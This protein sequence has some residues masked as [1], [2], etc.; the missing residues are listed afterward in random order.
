MALPQTTTHLVCAPDDLVGEAVLFEW[1]LLPGAE[2]LADAPL[3]RLAVEGEMRLVLTPMAGILTERCVAIGE[4]LAANDLL[5][6]IEAEEPD[7]G[8]LLIEPADAES[9]LALPACRQALPGTVQALREAS[10][11]AIDLC[12]ALGVAPEEVPTVDGRLSRA[13]VERHVRE[14]LRMLA[15]IRS[16][17]SRS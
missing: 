8:M 6:M 16:L 11:D 10:A 5:A 9:N 13:D 14:Q 12:A 4:T 15:S 7:F 3:A 2:V 17:L 1:L